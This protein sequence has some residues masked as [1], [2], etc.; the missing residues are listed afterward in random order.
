MPRLMPMTWYPVAVSMTEEGRARRVGGSPKSVDLPPALQ[1]TLA[2][3]N[4]GRI[5]AQRRPLLPRHVWSIRGHLE[6]AGNVR[7][8][9]LFNMA[10]DSKLRGC[11]VVIAVGGHRS[12]S[13]PPLPAGFAAV[14]RREWLCSCY[15][16]RSN[17]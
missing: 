9:T 10:V 5:I 2:A 11:A 15:K 7:D 4:N 14:G 17:H 3:S 6:M 12:L 13:R 8:P 16:H 1:P